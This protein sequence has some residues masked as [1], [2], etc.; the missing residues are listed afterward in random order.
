MESN[1][2]LV[3][4]QRK[5]QRGAAGFTLV[6][7]MIATLVLLIGLVAVARLVPLSIN[8]NQLNRNDSKSTVVA[9]QVLDQILSQTIDTTTAT[10]NLDGQN[11]VI[12]TGGPGAGATGS[13]IT[14]D[15]GQV[16]VKFAGAAVPGYNFVL[17]DPNN[18]SSPGIEVRLG[19]ITKAGGGAGPVSKR[20]VVGAWRR[21]NSQN[22]TFSPA[23]FDG[24][25][26]R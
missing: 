10:I 18:P 15:T 25:H 2:R 1:R 21:E 11:F 6:E 5:T 8:R 9:E 22:Q 16:E 12:Q 14:T 20:F 19:V 4:A 26:Q 23:I 7:V 13:P 17:F 3:L 24:F